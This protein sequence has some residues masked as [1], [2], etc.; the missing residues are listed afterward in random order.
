[1]YEPYVWNYRICVSELWTLLYCEF[2]NFELWVCKLVIFLNLLYY[3][4]VIFV[5]FYIMSLWY[6]WTWYIVNLWS[7]W[8]LSTLLYC[9]L[10]ILRYFYIDMFIN[11]I[12]DFDYY[13]C[14]F[15]DELSF[16]MF[17]KYRYH[18][19]FRSYCF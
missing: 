4:I 19:S 16:S 5:N 9:E 6:L 17:L 12:L 7:L 13:Q 1:M 3:E 10:V 2:V 15:H 14:I 11:H 18:F 8:Y